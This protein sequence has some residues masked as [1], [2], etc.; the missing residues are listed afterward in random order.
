MNNETQPDD[1][2]QQHE[3][4]ASSGRGK[5]KSKKAL[6]AAGIVVCFVLAYFGYHTYLNF[7]SHEST[8]DAFVEAHVVAISPKVAGHMA[9]VLVKDNQRVKQ[10]ELLV[11]V[12]PRDFQVALDIAKAQL[13]SAQATQKQAEAEVAVARNTL[14]QKKASLNSALATLAQEEAGVDEE[15][16]NHERYQQDLERSKKMA[17]VG[18]VSRQEYDHARAEASMSL[19]QLNS[20]HKQ[21]DTAKAQ[22][23]Q[24]KAAV[25]GAENELQQ[26]EAEVDVKTSELK[27]AEAEVEQ[28]TLN[29]SY[30]R[31][32]APMN[33]YVTK[34]SIEPG[35]YVQVGQQLMSIVGD[36][37]WVVANFKET[38]IA[39]MR[40]GQTVA[41]EVD[42]YPDAI[43]S[44]TIDS[45]Q[46][47]TGSRFT[48]LPPENAS[49]N[50]IKVV[51]RVPVKILI[52]RGKDASDYLLA[53]GMSV[54]P[55]V[56]ISHVH[57]SDQLN[58]GLDNNV[59]AAS[60]Q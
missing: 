17:D 37:S 34:K 52:Q 6:T 29:L 28:A 44:G 14:A 35:A 39:R 8:D 40:R 16:A 32:T 46:R 48:L 31:I 42:A 54:I 24:A 2:T 10:G 57:D 50:Y 58:A 18:A 55:T 9:R 19:A 56:D 47:G 59:K 11:E 26:A 25:S 13:Q 15:K 12:D 38:Q 43:F 41:I 20:A 1:T 36:D 27:E 4:P 33:G 3:P 23:V 22:I 53:P 51:Q 21:V 7:I 30:T 49:G 5:R 60:A 45:I